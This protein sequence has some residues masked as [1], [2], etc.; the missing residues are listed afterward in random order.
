M[1]RIL[2]LLLFLLVWLTPPAAADTYP[3]QPGIDAV[4]Y[5]FRLTLLTDETNVISGDA[6]V[7]LKFV[8]DGVKEVV[9]DLA[10]PAEG[11]G[12]TVS[13][14]TSAGQSVP[15][16]HQGDRLRIPLA[17]PSKAGQE[18]EF[19]I[20]YRGIPADGLRLIPN[21]HGERT[22]FSENWPN[23][24]RQWLPMI[25]HPYDKATGEFI[26]T[27]PAQYQVVANGLLLETVDVEHGLRRT[28]WKQSVPI[29][30]WLYAIGVARFAVHH[31]GLVRG[32]PLESWVFPQDRDNAYSLFEPAGRQA[33][34]FFSE[35][36]APYPYEKLGN[37]Q[38][39][40]IGGGTEHATA[41]FYGE[42]GVAAGRE[43]GVHG[44]PR[45]VHL[46]GRH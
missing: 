6:T 33:I 4:H 17:V 11:K 12:M 46:P 13:G 2:A 9:L 31:G 29:S 19:T 36:I 3:R 38:A 45:H 39:A 37:V 28:H 25:D 30:S 8:S 41:I 27:A 20:Q 44:P 14:V 23:K 24:A 15:F 7:S 42:K 32:V 26:I 43:G 21:I 40:G 34:E 10:S 1:K 18:L 16:T 35:R 22:A 5:V